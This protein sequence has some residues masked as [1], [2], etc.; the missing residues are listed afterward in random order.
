MAMAA[1]S[2]SASMMTAAV[3]AL[4]T[5]FPDKKDIILAYG[6]TS[7]MLTGITG[8]YMSLFVAI[9][10]SN[11]LYKISYRMKYGVEPEKEVRLK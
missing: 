11:W 10:L 9:P 3:V 6:A 7:N 5:M 8:L 1:G 2:G 4:Q